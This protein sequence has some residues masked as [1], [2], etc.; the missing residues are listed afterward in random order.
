MAVCDKCKKEVPESDIVTLS[1]HRRICRACDRALE[2]DILGSFS[3]VTRIR[4][5][6]EPEEGQPSSTTHPP[7]TPPTP[8]AAL[9]QP[10]VRFKCPQCARS[11][12]AKEGGAG[13]AFPCPACGQRIT[14]P[15]SCHATGAPTG[16]DW[17]AKNEDIR[18]KV[19]AVLEFLEL[20]EA[21]GRLVGCQ[22]DL[23]VILIAIIIGGSCRVASWSLSSCVCVGIGV[24]VIVE[25][26][27]A[28]IS[29]FANAASRK[30]LRNEKET[31]FQETFLPGSQDYDHA[32]WAL[33]MVLANRVIA[34][35]NKIVVAVH[36]RAEIWTKYLRGVDLERLSVSLRQNELRALKKITDLCPLPTNSE[37]RNCDSGDGSVTRER[38]PLACDSGVKFD[39]GGTAA[40]FYDCVFS[41]M[42]RRIT[43][44]PSEFEVV[45]GT[46]RLPTQMLAWSLKNSQLGL[47]KE[48]ALWLAHTQDERAIA[49]LGDALRGT[50]VVWMFL[51]ANALSMMARYGC[52]LAMSE[53]ERISARGSDMSAVI[54]AHAFAAEKGAELFS[55]CVTIKGQPHSE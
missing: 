25:V 47:Q 16:A 17:V 36:S 18:H 24:L 31:K 11:L 33:C 32:K 45:A 29:A 46:D 6:Q 52:G 13:Q 53:M 2:R 50:D 30:R 48:A 7:A 54:A 27:V 26:A 15:Q 40:D 8:S 20:R 42:N 49:V 21:R 37:I 1:N 23:L 55:S 43:P 12:V 28:Y 51:A 38:L 39:V 22:F 41:I 44:L 10:S 5:S 14:I 34:E 4:P 3:V 35:T 9:P 19:N